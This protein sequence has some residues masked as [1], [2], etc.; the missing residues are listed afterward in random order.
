MW[1]PCHPRPWSRTLGYT[2]LLHWSFCL[3]QNRQGFLWSKSCLLGLW[4]LA[5]T[6]HLWMQFQSTPSPSGWNE[7][8]PSQ[9][10]PWPKALAGKQEWKTVINENL[11]RTA[12]CFWRETLSLKVS[13]CCCFYVPS[14]VWA[15][16]A[17]NISCLKWA[18]VSLPGAPRY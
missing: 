14:G 10:T 13:H 18:I 2:G 15:K 1:G 17:S 5:L 11:D 9:A 6:F 4:F 3:G 16:S 7:M 8:P 12:L